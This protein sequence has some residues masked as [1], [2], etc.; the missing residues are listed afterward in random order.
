MSYRPGDPE[1]ERLLQ[2]LI[3]PERLVV[4]MQKE[5]R[6]S[7]DQPGKERRT[8]E[9]DP[10]GIGRSGDPIGRSDGGDAVAPDQ[11]R[12]AWAARIGHAVPDGGGEQENRSNRI[13]RRRRGLLDQRD[14][15]E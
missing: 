10:L 2:D 13:G 8:R 6:M 3:I 9:L 11:H 1:R 14:E 5:V 4:R 12:P 15:E 7:F